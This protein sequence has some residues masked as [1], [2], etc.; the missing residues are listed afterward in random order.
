[1]P[2]APAALRALPLLPSAAAALGAGLRAC[3]RCRPNVSPGAPEWVARAD[4]VARAMRLIA[5][6]VVDRGGVGELAARLGYSPRQV[7]RA[8]TQELGAGPLA[9]ARVQ[10]AQA[11]RTLI[12]ST[13]LPMTEIAFAAGFDSIRQFNDTVR[14]VFAST[15]TELRRRV[16]P[17]TP[18]AASTVEL[19]L[20]VR[21]PFHAEGVLAHLAATAVPGLEQWRDGAYHRTMTLDHGPAVVSLRPADGHVAASLRLTDHRDLVSAVARCRW[22]LDLDADPDAIDAA[23]AEDPLLRAAVRADPGRRV[24]RCVDGGELALRIVLGQQVSTAAARTVT[25]RIVAALGDPLPPALRRDELD[26]RF[27]FPSPAAVAQMDPAGLPMPRRRADT[28]I[29]LAGALA[30]GDLDLSPG[31]DRPAA[32]DLLGRLP[33]VGPWTTGSV[34]MRALGDPDAF[35]PTD[36]G[37][38]AAARGLGLASTRELVARSERWRPWRSYAT[39]VLWGLLDHPVAHLPVEAPRPPAAGPRPSAP[40]PRV[41]AGTPRVPARAGRSRRTG[42]PRPAPSPRPAPAA[43]PAPASRPPGEV[44]A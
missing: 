41:P 28:L 10:R 4:V 37:V 23:L 14:T 43:R 34:A 7:H 2:G 16:R 21:R 6:G 31:A 40:G 15:P 17:G 42:R 5:D 9:L 25:A 38:A 30:R 13:P 36:L 33:G 35:L 3:K 18:T 24:P 44:P 32:L 19:R 39:Q 8:L 11:A 1:V 27:T 12:E 20:A 26:L 22:L 29:A